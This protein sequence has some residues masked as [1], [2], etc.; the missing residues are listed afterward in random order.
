VD[1][2]NALDVDASQDVEG[3]AD[4][5]VSVPP[6]SIAIDCNGS[7]PAPSQSA[8]SQESVEPMETDQTI[9]SVGECGLITT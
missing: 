1:L 8:N 3:A 4:V 5:D 2:S 9:A 6:P 7:N